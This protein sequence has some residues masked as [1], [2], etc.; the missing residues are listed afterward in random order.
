MNVR[1]VIKIKKNNDNEFF[2][3]AQLGK[4][5]ITVAQF[6]IMCDLSP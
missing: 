6:C 4:V 1:Q 5:L 2:K 3:K